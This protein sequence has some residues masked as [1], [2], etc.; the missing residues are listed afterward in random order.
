MEQGGGATM[1]YGGGRRSSECGA[2]QLGRR[3]AAVVGVVVVV[4]DAMGLF[5]GGMRR[6]GSATA[7]R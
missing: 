1:A 3:L 2:V 4:G 7:G 5:I 6:W